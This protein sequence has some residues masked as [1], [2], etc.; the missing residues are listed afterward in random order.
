[1]AGAAERP[2]CSN[3]CPRVALQNI[4]TREHALDAAS[5]NPVIAAFRILA[6]DTE[7]LN[8]LKENTQTLAGWAACSSHGKPPEC[9]APSP[10]CAAASLGIAESIRP[11]QNALVAPDE[12]RAVGRVGLGGDLFPTANPF[13]EPEAPA[14]S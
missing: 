11:L 8:S 7:I 6:G 1:M 2:S 14:T 4:R 3:S 12:A 9:W 5:L 13:P 10:E